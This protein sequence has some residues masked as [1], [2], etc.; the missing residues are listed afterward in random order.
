[1]QDRTVA[2]ASVAYCSCWDRGWPSTRCLDP[3]AS[4]GNS[5]PERACPRSSCPCFHP[6]RPQP[7]HHHHHH[8]STRCLLYHMS[9]SLC[10][11]IAKTLEGACPRPSCPCFHPARPQPTI[12]ITTAQDVPMS[13]CSIIAN[14]LEGACPRATVAFTVA[15]TVAQCQSHHVTTTTA[16]I[17][18]TCKR[19]QGNHLQMQLS[20]RS[21]ST[22]GA[23]H[24]TEKKAGV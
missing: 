21:S 17:T 22:R 14:T 23:Q 16:A 5:H 24:A 8:D 1:M 9:M 3:S 12:A 7:H 13:L 4:T 2:L 11:I 19:L 15:F 6:A 18:T 20:H 10:F